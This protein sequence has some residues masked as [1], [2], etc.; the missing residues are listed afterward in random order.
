[1]PPEVEGIT[2]AAPSEPA[3]P[4]PAPA[5][6]PV[7]LQAPQTPETGEA[8]E[9]EFEELEYDDVK[10]TA[11]KSKAQKLREA[12]LRQDDYTRKTQGVAA[13]RKAL[14][15]E[16]Q[17]LEQQAKAVVEH[18][19]ELGQLA[20]VEA[21]IAQFETYDWDAWE[22]QDPA[23]AARGW[24][25]YQQSKEYKA[26]LEQKIAGREQ[27]R[28]QRQTEATQQ[29]LRETRD[30]AQK[31]IKG[32]TPELDS[33]IERHAI[34]DLGY[35]RDELVQLVNPKT[36]RTLHRSWMLSETSR[37]QQ[38]DAKPTTPAIQPLATVATRSSP[39]AKK[40]L[41]DPTLP[42]AEYARRRAAGEKG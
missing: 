42:M 39:G 35:T 30:Y 12:L 37:Q 34:E 32:W 24:R 33:Q 31:N 3:T 38:A 6:E 5:D 25:Q 20:A 41:T 1:M 15:T 36:Y 19:Q 21:Q 7:N 17:T 40:A 16:R 27:E 11:P 13:D 4:A 28:T 22:L 29:R 14:E 26:G 8:V 2:T 9:E 23:A 10:F 18:R